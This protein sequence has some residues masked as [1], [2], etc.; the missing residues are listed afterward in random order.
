MDVMHVVGANVG[1]LFSNVVIQEQG[2][3]IVKD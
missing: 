1:L 2:N 3:K